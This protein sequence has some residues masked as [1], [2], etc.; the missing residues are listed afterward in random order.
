MVT[1]E[2]RA[3]AGSSNAI[4]LVFALLNDAE[5]SEN[6]EDDEDCP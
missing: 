2:G 6:K 4:T 3:G 5:Q 1:E